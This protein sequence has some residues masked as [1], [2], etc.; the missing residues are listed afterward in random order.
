MPCES[1]YCK[2]L[3]S[4]QSAYRIGSVAVTAHELVTVL[5]MA[6]LIGV[7]PPALAA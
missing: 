6:V 1:G 3:H 2:R 4:C 7:W 5:V